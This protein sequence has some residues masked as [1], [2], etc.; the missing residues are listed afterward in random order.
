MSDPRLTR[1]AASL[2]AT[3]PFIGPEQHERDRNM[4]I[5]ARIGANESVFGPSPAAVAAM[6]QAAEEAWKYPDAQ[7]HDLRQALAAETG[8]AMENIV[9]GSGIDGL[10]GTLVRLTVAPGDP[11]VSSAGAYPTFN[12]HVAGHGGVLHTVPYRNDHE[13]P[14]AL[15]ARAREVGAKLVY[16][17]NPDNPMGTWHGSGRIERMVEQVPEESLLVLDEAY[18]DCAPHQSAP[19]IRPGDPRVIRMRTF[20]KAHGLAGARIGYALGPEGLIAAFDR[21]RDHFGV[22][23]LAQAG[24]LAALED[25]AYLAEVQARISRSRDRLDEIARAN[26]LTA[27]PSATNFVAI[28]LDGDGA[29]ARR[30]VEALM[31]RGIFVRM[32]GVAPLDRCLRVSCG[33]D[34]EMDL[35]AEALPGVLTEIR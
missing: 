25:R 15:I 4:T 9:V 8:A 26:G 23:R 17:S 35:F 28:D 33:G 16:I 10:L 11:V 13:D 18:F 2:P 6:A 20:S 24:A 21:V 3:V 5:R 31:R 12:Y 22:S 27:I 7:C 1:L 30:A 19:A 32:P 14:D 34:R 29:R